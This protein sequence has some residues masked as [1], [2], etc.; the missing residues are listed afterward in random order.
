MVWTFGVVLLRRRLRSSRRRRDSFVTY[1]YDSCVLL[2]L[3]VFVSCR[4]RYGNP[5]A[6][7]FYNLEARD[8]RGER[9]LDFY[10]SFVD[11][12]HL[13]RSFPDMKLTFTDDAKEKVGDGRDESYVKVVPIWAPPLR[14]QGTKRRERK[15]KTYV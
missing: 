15:N 10:D 7:A 6:A 5:G 2:L 9:M 14:A 11:R 8:G 1:N 3:L 13:E 4:I 12:P